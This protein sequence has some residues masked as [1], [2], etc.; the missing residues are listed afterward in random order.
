MTALLLLNLV[1]LPADGSIHFT[2]QQL[3]ERYYCDGVA[4]GDINRDGHPDVVAGPYWYA[5]PGF[6]T[7]TEIYPAVA[8]PPEPS[9]SNSMFSFVRDFNNDGWPDVLVLGRV[10]KHE[11]AWY[12]NPGDTDEPWARHFVFA[13]VRGESPTLT[14]ITHAK[15]PQL[16]CHWEGRWGWIQPQAGQPRK[17][18]QFI[19]IGDQRDWP[20]FYH[21]QGIGDI[22]ADGR[23]DIIINDGWYEQPAEAAGNSSGKKWKFHATRFSQ[24]RGGAQMFAFDVDGDG[25]NDVVSAVHAH[26]WGLAWYE[27]QPGNGSPT[28]VEHL[29]MGDRSQEE[30]FGVAFSQPHAVQI[31]DLDGDGLTDVICGKRIW[32]HG[33][34]GDVEPNADPVVYWFQLQRDANGTVRFVP[35]QIDDRSGVGV[36]ITTADLNQDGR[37]D[38]LTASKLGTFV[39]MNKGTQAAAPPRE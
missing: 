14:H 39:F 30:K 29:M 5:G 18:W 28:F 2:K 13:R 36:Q 11:A 12:E 25:D 33:P 15:V 38:I 37:P 8:L 26:E 24:Q 27:Q 17:P 10:H 4:A 16:L 34:T 35:H 3:T 1:C 21:G 31:A 22:N 7:K 23:P 19:A 6:E 32:A 20:Q 9:P